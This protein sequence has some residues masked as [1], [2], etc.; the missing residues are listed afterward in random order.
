MEMQE[1]AELIL[2]KDAQVTCP[3]CK[4][5]QSFHE[6]LAENYQPLSEFSIFSSLSS[7]NIV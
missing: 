3:V 1:L 2:G 7:K 6:L 5:P 4:H